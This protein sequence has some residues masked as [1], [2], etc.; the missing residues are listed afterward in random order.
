MNKRNKPT[1]AFIGGGLMG[2][3]IIKNILKGGYAV[4][5][6]DHPGNRPID[7]LVSGGACVGDSVQAMASQADVIFIC[8]TGTPEV[9]N[10]MLSP[11]G[12]LAGLQEGSIVVDCSTALPQ[13]TLKLAAAVADKGASYVDAPMTRTP[14]EAEEGRLNVMLG[15]AAV[16]LDAVIDIINC[17]AENVYRTGPVGSGHKMKLIHNYLALGNAVLAGEAVACAQKCGVDMETFCEVIMTGGGDS[18]VFRRLLPYIQQGDD[19]SFRFSV[20]NAEKDLRYYNAMAEGLGVSNAGSVA[21]HGVLEQAKGAGM[22]G[23]SMPSLIEYF[24]ELGL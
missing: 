3:G 19:S 12:V 16:A 22:G 11:D 1:I 20:A 9:E 2:H 24:K 21:V 7:D 15:G 18:L 5:I 4:T 6:L 14:K 23:K 17:Y 13:S 10:V 8:V